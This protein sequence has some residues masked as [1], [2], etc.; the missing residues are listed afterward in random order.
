MTGM[1][2]V[3]ASHNA[4]KLREMRELLA[5]YGW[6]LAPV[7][8]YD[9]APVDEPA[10]TF[11]ENALLKARHACA[12]SGRPAIADD[13]GLEV[14]ALGGAPGV[15]SARYAGEQANAQANV[16]ANNAKLLQALAGYPEAERGARFICVMV[17]LRHAEDPTPLVAT[18]EWAGRILE[19]PSGEAGFGY[20]PVFFDPQRGCSAAE[21][22][23]ATKHRYSHRGQALRQLCELLKDS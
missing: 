9:S 23:A 17:Y 10:P 3:L 4:G 16:Q 11:V 20:D 22:D 12:V 7:S 5:P 2:L 13:S 21:M 14:A 15:R 8:D 19:T 1:E 18:G 6:R